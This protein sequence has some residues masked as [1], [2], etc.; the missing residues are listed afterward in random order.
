[1]KRIGR[2]LALIFVIALPV[3]L[4]TS[5][6]RW[7]FN[8][9][10]IYES[11]F[12][13][14]NVSQT[15]GLSEEQLSDAAVQIRDYFNSGDQELRLLVGAEEGPRELLSARDVLHMSD[16]KDLVTGMYR[17]QEGTFLYLFLFLTLGFLVQGSDFATHLRK[18]LV[19]GSAVSVGVVAAIGL[20]AVVAFG[21]LF[22]LFHQIS[23]ANDFWQGDPSQG[24][25]LVVLFPFDFWRETT[26]LIGVATIVEA[27]VIVGL[28]FAIRWWQ[29][30]RKR[31]AQSKA[32]QFV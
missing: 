6:V 17:V 30:R 27:G 2:L 3:F 21:P 24:D 13:R 8:S 7:A 23:F 18:I 10:A 12:Q 5:N 9:A 28:V 31:V 1:M 22:N 19:R 25:F 32:P 14:H 15:T 20:V 26:M 11:G 29:A 4:I 16:V